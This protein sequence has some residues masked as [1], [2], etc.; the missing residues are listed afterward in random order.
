MTSSESGAISRKELWA[1]DQ[2]MKESRQRQKRAD[3]PTDIEVEQVHGV[4]ERIKGWGVGEVRG[5]HWHGGV[6]RECDDSN[7]GSEMKQS[8]NEIKSA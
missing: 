7:E 1:D 4:G 2:K 3:H 5:T 8:R 6:I